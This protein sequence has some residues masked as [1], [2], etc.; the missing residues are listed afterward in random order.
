MVSSAS[1]NAMYLPFARLIPL[2]RENPGPLCPLFSRQTIRGSFFAASFTTLNDP[3][4]PRSFT[5]MNS[6]SLSVCE[7]NAVNNSGKYR[8][9]RYTG[10]MTDTQIFVKIGVSCRRILSLMV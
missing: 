5:K 9:A 1:A 7:H 6:I 3:S 8:F 2:F 10:T 4:P